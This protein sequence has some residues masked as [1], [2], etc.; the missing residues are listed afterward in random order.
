M[1]SY[2]PN[3]LIPH[4]TDLLDIRRALTNTLKRVTSKLDLILHVL[5]GLDIDS[6]LHSDT[7]HDLFAQEVPVPKNIST[8][9]FHT[10]SKPPVSPERFG[11]N[12]PNLHFVHPLRVLLNIDINRKMRIYVTH[13]ILE[14]SRNSDNEILNERLDGAKRGHIL[15]RSV[16][17]LDG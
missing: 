16:V 1:G 3:I 6:R 12:V 14:A 4:P 9:P 7:S 2:L 5:R 11:R 8:Q 10:P 13:L 17:Q 15:A